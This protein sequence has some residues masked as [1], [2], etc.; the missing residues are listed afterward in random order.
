MERDGDWIRDGGALFSP[1]S[2]GTFQSECEIKSAGGG[3]KKGTLVGK[4]RY[5]TQGALWSG[6]QRGSGRHEGFANNSR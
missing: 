6:R 1:G 4:D 3:D 5:I 2:K